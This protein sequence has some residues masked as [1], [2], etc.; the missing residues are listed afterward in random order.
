MHNEKQPGAGYNAPYL[1]RVGPYRSEAQRYDPHSNENKAVHVVQAMHDQVCSKNLNEAKFPLI[2]CNEFDIKNGVPLTVDV[3]AANNPSQPAQIVFYGNNFV[4]PQG[5]AI[6][7]QDIVLEGTISCNDQA[8]DSHPILV[9]GDFLQKQLDDERLQPIAYTSN[10]QPTG[11]LKKM[12]ESNEA[13]TAVKYTIIEFMATNDLSCNFWRSSG[14]NRW[15]IGSADRVAN[16]L[17]GIHSAPDSAQKFLVAPFLNNQASS[18]TL[19]SKS[20][21]IPL[22]EA[23]FFCFHEYIATYGLVLSV[24]TDKMDCF[25]KKNTLIL[26][27]AIDQNKRWN[28]RCIKL[29]AGEFE[30]R[31]IAENLGENKGEIGFL[32]IG[33]SRDST[34]HHSIC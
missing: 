19:V 16:P 11:A 15:E 10:S 20:L 23:V 17:T 13:Q 27:D 25:Y 18:Y 28:I 32:P 33:L 3:P 2:N 22:I 7:L 5:G 4:A 8:L 21:T 9:G 14:K 29:P 24:C 26:G 30:L 31:V 1:P 6:F 12:D 34:G